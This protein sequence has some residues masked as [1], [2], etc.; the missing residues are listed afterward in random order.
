MKLYKLESVRGFAAF[1]VVLHHT[2]N[3]DGVFSNLF[4]FGQEAVILFFFM[5]GFVIHYSFQKSKDKRFS[6]YFSNRF[7][8]LY[9]PLFCI[10]ILGYLV[11]SYRVGY[12]IDPELS[13]LIKNI[14]MLQDIESLKP[15]VI[16]PP[17]MGNS[18]LWSLSY[19]WWFYMLYYPLC[20]Q[21]RVFKSN[22]H[23]TFT[24]SCLGAVLYVLEPSFATRIAMYF[25]IWFSGVYI[26][27]LYLEG[28]SLNFKNLSYPLLNLFVITLVLAVNVAFYDFKNSSVY[29]GV[30]PILELRHFAFAL[31]VLPMSLVWRKYNWVGFDVIFKPFMRLA[32]ISYVMYI[33]HSY[34][35]SSASYLDFVSSPVLEWSGYIIVLFIFSY[36][37]EIIIYPR[38]RSLM[39]AIINSKVV[40]KSLG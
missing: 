29:I 26:A 5:S 18:P 16:A 34:L 6:R 19:E 27:E 9:I 4:K 38:V 22:M 32:P 33:S 12:F 31:V 30:H 8:R 25:S 1:Y 40:N 10:F 17:Y 37:V 20:N 13:N 36:L 23:I 35:V 2:V 39:M 7:Y 14:L 28:R 15:A 3:V 11:S 21:G 24:L